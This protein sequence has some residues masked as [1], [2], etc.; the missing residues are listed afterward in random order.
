MPRL[1][2]LDYLEQR[3]RLMSA[4]EFSPHL[5]AELEFRQQRALHDFFAVSHEMYDEE[6]IAYRQAQAK[7]FPS[8]PQRAGRAYV[9]FEE[10]VAEDRRRR[11][12]APTET[13]QV[14][15]AKRPRKIVR[16]VGLVRPQIDTKKIAEILVQLAIEDSGNELLE[17]LRK[18]RQK[19]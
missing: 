11:A 14:S 3:R 16:V 19:K 9:C 5:I 18:R 2:N 13:V 7:S 1:T 10:I 17:K 6:V 4:W 15:G 12:M 8:L